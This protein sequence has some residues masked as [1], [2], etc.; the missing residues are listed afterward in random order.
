MQTNIK[1]NFAHNS[2]EE[3]RTEKLTVYTVFRRNEVYVAVTE[4]TSGR[5]VA[6]DANGSEVFEL[7]EC[8]E[9]LAVGHGVVKVA[10]VQRRHCSG[11]KPTS[12]NSVTF[13]CNRGM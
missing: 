4:G 3:N 10:D 11:Q 9:E 7:R 12:E 8:F 5:R 13:L 6:T 2:N 1:L